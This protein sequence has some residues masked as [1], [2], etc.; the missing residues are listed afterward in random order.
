MTDIKRILFVDTSNTCRAHMAEGWARHLKKEEIEPYSA[1]VEAGRLDPFAVRVM[2]ETGID[3]QQ[4]EPS[5]IKEFQNAPLDY[6]IA[7]SRTALEAIGTFSGKAVL[8]HQ[9][10]ESPFDLTSSMTDEDD[11]LQVYRRI[12]DE[13]RAFVETLPEAVC[14]ISDASAS[15]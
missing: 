10:F 14:A 4:Q 5:R 15:G 2:K 1:G 8:V 6:I 9:P 13:I 12:R 11:K 3:I 7:V